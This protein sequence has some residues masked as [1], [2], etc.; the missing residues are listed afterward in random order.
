MT[1]WLP[2]DLVAGHAH[3]A[4]DDRGVCGLCGRGLCR[5]EKIAQL[6]DGT[7]AHVPCLVTMPNPA[8]STGS[9]NGE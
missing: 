3:A 1:G 7:W 4:Q 9:D 8:A 5:R 6:T 2:G